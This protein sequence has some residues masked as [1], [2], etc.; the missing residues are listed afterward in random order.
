M[1]ISCFKKLKKL[2]SIKKA[3]RSIGLPS[4]FLSIHKLIRL[5]RLM[6]VIVVKARF[7]LIDYYIFTLAS[8]LTII[9][10]LAMATVSPF[11]FFISWMTVTTP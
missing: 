4:E 11:C 2:E 1:F 10:M 6:I 5:T 7:T 9:F 3:S 8:E